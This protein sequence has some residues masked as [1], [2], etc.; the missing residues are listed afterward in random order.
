[1]ATHRQCTKNFTIPD[2]NIE[3]EKGTSLI[4]PL[5]KI[6]QDPNNFPEPNK[7]DPERFSPENKVTR[8]SCAFI[9]FGE[10][11]RMCIGKYS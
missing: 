4:I 3:I 6:H 8:H 5:Y 11:P 9:P 10:G 1:M 7:F 2:T